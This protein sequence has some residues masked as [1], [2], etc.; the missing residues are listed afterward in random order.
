MECKDFLPFSH[1][2]LHRFKEERIEDGGHIMMDKIYHAC[3]GHSLGHTHHDGRFFPTTYLD[4]DRVSLI[5][6]NIAFQNPMK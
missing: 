3:V 5:L 2:N 6:E 1:L 4:L